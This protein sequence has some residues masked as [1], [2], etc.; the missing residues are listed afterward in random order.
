MEEVAAEQLVDEEGLLRS[1][2]DAERELDSVG[3]ACAL[4]PAFQ[5]KGRHYGR[6]L[7]DLLR[8]GKGLTPEL[9]DRQARVH[10]L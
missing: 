8:A 1:P 7:S 4:D 10:A 2:D 6:F 5:R 3:E 9:Q